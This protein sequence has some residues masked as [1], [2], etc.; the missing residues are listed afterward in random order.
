M[1]P[2]LNYH[3]ADVLVDGVSVGAVT[4]HTISNVT[5]NQ[6]IHTTFAPDTRVIT[7]T[8]GENGEISPSGA[9]DVVHGGSQAFTLSPAEGFQVADVLVDGVSV[10]A[11]T[12]HTFSDVTGN[13]TI[14][15]SFEAVPDAGSPVALASVLPAEG[16]LLAP[17]NVLF[18]FNTSGGSDTTY[19]LCLRP[20]DGNFDPAT[21]CTTVSG[22]TALLGK[23]VMFAGV[24]ATGIGFFWLA[25]SMLGAFMKRSKTVM[26]AFLVV[27][28][29]LL[30]S[31]SGGGGGGG[32]SGTTTLTAARQNLKPDTTYFW[33]V[34]ATRQG[35]TT[36]TTPRSFKTL[37]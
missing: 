6:T 19:Q 20:G 8:S 9:V 15:V 22:A 26:L 30:S 34:I 36:E 5:A 31:C 17:D 29:L 13:H 3:V 14:G 10:G 32:A 35:Q 7:A 12:T 21:D 1:T 23:G 33:K 11:V 16:D 25:G 28:G 24:G 4:T 37:P 18:T 2:D 27:A